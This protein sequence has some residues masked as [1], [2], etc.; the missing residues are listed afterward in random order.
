MMYGSVF[1][2]IIENGK[3]TLKKKKFQILIFFNSEK[4]PRNL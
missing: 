3:K 2:D 4:F 1:K